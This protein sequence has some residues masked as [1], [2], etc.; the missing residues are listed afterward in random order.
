MA[1]PAAAAQRRGMT[2]TVPTAP[3]LSGP[4]ELVAAL[5]LLC[6]FV[7]RESLVVVC[8]EGSRIGLTLRLDLPDVAQEADLVAEVAARARYSG[9]SQAYL[10][11]VTEEAGLPRQRLVDALR[12]QVDAVDALLVRG[13]RW[14]SYLCRDGACCPRDGTPVPSTSPG[15]R[16][17]QAEA[18]LAG[19]AVLPSREDLVASLAPPELP[20]VRLVALQ[21]ASERLR[22]ERGRVGA[23]TVRSRLLA[24]VR[25]ALAAEP[26][27]A[28]SSESRNERGT[29]PRSQRLDERQTVPPLQLHDALDDDVAAE[30]ALALADVVV[31]DEVLTWGLGEDDALLAL[32]V[33]LARLTPAPHDAGVCACLAWVAYGRGDGA[34]ASVALD[35]ALATDPGH[36]LALLLAQALHAQVPP[37]QLRAVAARAAVDLRRRRRR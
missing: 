22:E 20:G 16:R 9:A 15:L 33:R 36:G 23:A 17:V 3:R 21:Q 1:G 14:W 18:V 19:R 2:R 29:G 35:R 27:A 12:A 13:G 28:G 10:V 5:P 6:G 24:G 37:R 8:L 32:L 25:S 11:V 26:G 7:P 30:L 34:T 4:G 31:R